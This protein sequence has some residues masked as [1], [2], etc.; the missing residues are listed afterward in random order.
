M[1][2]APQFLEGFDHTILRFDADYLRRHLD[3]N[4]RH[5][6]AI[7]GMPTKRAMEW[8]QTQVVQALKGQLNPS[9]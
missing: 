9:G 8:A 7:N 1:E 2:R 6:E 5:L 4:L 3:Q